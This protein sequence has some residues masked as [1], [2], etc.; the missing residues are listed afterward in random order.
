LD[1]LLFLLVDG[2]TNGAVYGLVALSLIVVYTVTRVVNIAQG[3]YITLG[4]LSFASALAGSFN[5]LSALVAGGS[6]CLLCGMSSIGVSGKPPNSASCCCA[7]VGSWACSP[8]VLR[9][10]FRR[11]R[12]GSRS[13]PPWSR[14][15]RLDVSSIG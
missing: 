7:P 12:I 8:P 5:L 3:E 2:V 15:R 14:P 9:L 10:L 1:T 11:D 13:W 6:R 4:A